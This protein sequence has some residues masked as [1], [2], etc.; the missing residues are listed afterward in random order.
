MDPENYKKYWSLLQD[1]ES[2][3]VTFEKCDHDWGKCVAEFDKAVIIADGEDKQGSRGV[4]LQGPK[5]GVLRWSADEDNL[6]DAKHWTLKNKQYA[7]IGELI[8]KNQP[9]DFDTMYVPDETTAGFELSPPS[10]PNNVIFH[11]MISWKKSATYT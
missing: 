10:Y 4:L 6:V 5:N 11:A 2:K 1:R 3:K 9:T 8:V 7:L